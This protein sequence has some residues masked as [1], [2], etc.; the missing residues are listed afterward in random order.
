M[1]KRREYLNFESD[2]PEEQPGQWSDE[3]LIEM[4]QREPQF[5]SILVDRYEASFVRVAQRIVRNPEEAEDVVQNAFVKIYRFANHFKKD[6]AKFKSWAYK[7]VVNMAI[8]HYNKRKNDAMLIPEDYDPT[9][10][11]SQRNHRAD[12][13]SRGLESVIASA[14]EE[15]PED[16]QSLLKAYYLDDKSY[17]TIAAGEGLSIGALK[18]KLF[19]ARKS[20]K[21]VLE[22]RKEV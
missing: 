12:E 15:I 16:L 19:R 6:Q 9:T 13:H 14:L 11:E 1:T 4:A 21:G 2:D 20:L 3:T 17:K 10:A 8:T 5:F 22:Q 18:M 7:I